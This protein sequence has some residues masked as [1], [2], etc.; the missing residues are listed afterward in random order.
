MC[1]WSEYNVLVC[2]F[3]KWGINLII[4]EYGSM[5]LRKAKDF[6]SAHTGHGR[7]LLSEKCVYVNNTINY[8]VILGLYYDIFMVGS[9]NQI[10][11]FIKSILIKFI[12]SIYLKFVI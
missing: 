10:I 1:K 9:N 2:E 12:K 6:S 7:M 4:L 3:V 5:L 11:K 8:Y